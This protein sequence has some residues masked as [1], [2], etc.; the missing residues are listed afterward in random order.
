MLHKFGFLFERSSYI[1]PSS[2]LSESEIQQ[3]SQIREN[4]IIDLKVLGDFNDLQYLSKNADNQFYQSKIDEHQHLY[5]QVKYISCQLNDVLDSDQLRY[6][7]RIIFD[8]ATK[9]KDPLVLYHIFDDNENV[10]ENVI[11]YKGWLGYYPT[12]VHKELTKKYFT[13]QKF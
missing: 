11:K 1:L 12:E 2:K 8:T 3:L 9:N 10:L 4:L 5:S 6:N 13:D 7:L